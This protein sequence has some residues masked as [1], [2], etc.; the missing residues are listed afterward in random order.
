MDTRL[1]NLDYV[2]CFLPAG[3]LKSQHAFRDYSM[4]RELMP[5]LGV[6]GVHSKYSLGEVG[7]V[8]SGMYLGFYFLGGW[9]SLEVK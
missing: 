7:I 2:K 4:P 1:A 5:I 3:R 8:A 6:G 9:C